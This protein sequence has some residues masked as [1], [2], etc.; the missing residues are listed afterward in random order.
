MTDAAPKLLDY[1][2]AIYHE[3]PF[4]NQFLLAFE[5]VLL[6]R[7]SDTN[8]PAK[9]IEQTIAQLPK[10]FDPN[11]TPDPF[12][13][14]LSGW[15]AFSGRADLQ[16]IQQRAFISQVISLYRR[17]GTKEN[18][19]ELLKI[20][21]RGEPII[22]EPG[23]TEF[24]VGPTASIGETTFIAGGVPHYFE[25]EINIPGDLDPNLRSR[26]IEIARALIELEKPAHTYYKLI[27]NVLSTIQIGEQSTIGVNT[28]L[29]TP[30]LQ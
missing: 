20:F 28:I 2:P 7:V 11:Q 4:L 8:F 3:D 5:E 29:G 25:V 13:D 15:V 12:L 21:V 26:Q 14:W 30:N 9:G 22:R 10:L 17:R 6:G 1:L 18:L 27:P 24:Q 16:P 19:Q 23:G